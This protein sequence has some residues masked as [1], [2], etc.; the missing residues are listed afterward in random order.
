[1]YYAYNAYLRFVAMVEHEDDCPAGCELTTDEPPSTPWP[2]GT[3]PYYTADGWELA[4]VQ[5]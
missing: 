3:W 2:D 5:H 1:M 4:E